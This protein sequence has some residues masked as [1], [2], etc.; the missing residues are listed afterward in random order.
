MNKVQ[1]HT[2][3]AR[4]IFKTF[5]QLV[6]TRLG[7][8]FVDILKSSIKEIYRM[9]SLQTIVWNYEKILKTYL[10]FVFCSVKKY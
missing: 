7:D 10:G 2:Y 5:P 8:I 4:Y 6:T 1:F 9:V 3:V